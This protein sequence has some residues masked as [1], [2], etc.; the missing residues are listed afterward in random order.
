MLRAAANAHPKETGGILVGVRI[1]RHP[2]INHA[3]EIHDLKATT[4]RYSI[5][6]GSRPFAVN[7]LRGADARIGYLGEWHAHP[8]DRGPSSHDAGSIAEITQGIKAASRSAILIVVRRRRTGYGLDISEW[9]G[10]K[11]RPITL[12]LAGNLPP[13]QSKS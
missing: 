2:W 9:R 6:K 1:G 12:L 10:T 13:L 4:H 5:P 7:H 3:V 8:A 11:F